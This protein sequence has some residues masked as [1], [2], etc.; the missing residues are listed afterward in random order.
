MI[1]TM[2]IALLTK[3]GARTRITDE[4]RTEAV[5]ENLIV[6]SG[7]EDLQRVLHGDTA[8]YF[9]VRARVTDFEKLQ[10]KMIRKLIRSRALE[11]FRLKQK[12]YM[13]SI[14]GV[15]L[16]TFD[17]EPYPG[18]CFRKD[19]NGNKKWYCYKLQA[20]LVTTKGFCLPIGY[21]WIENEE[22]FDKQDCELK[23]LYRLVKKLREMYPRLEM[24]LLL[25]GLFAGQPTFKAVKESRMEYIVVFKEGS[26]SYI[27]PWVMDIKRQ[28]GKDNVIVETEE[29]EIEDRQKRTHEERLL[30]KKAKNVTRIVTTQTT[31]TWMRG[32]EFSDDRSLFNIMT[33]K[34][35][36]EGEKV[37]DYVWLVS[38]GLNLNEN[39]VKQFAKAGRCRWKIENEGNNMQKNGGYNLEHLYSRDKVS[40]RVWCML[41]D[42]ACIINQLI[43]KGSLIAIEDYGSIRNFAQRMFEHFRYFVYKEPEVVPKIQ[44]RLCWDSW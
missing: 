26:M 10:A 44:I 25:D 13:V 30:R 24:C 4:L 17:Y 42:I 39:N 31:Y 28:C 3:R 9:S 43:E 12:Y 21:E 7:Q 40:M 36:Y 32:I 8:E 18:C 19:D 16:Y 38:D 23:A 37:C 11:K 5:C 2:L 29:K 27:Y 34:E 41:I 33:C 6:L 14:D 35:L 20:S 1:W 15:H 22:G